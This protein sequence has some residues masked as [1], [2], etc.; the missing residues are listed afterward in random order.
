MDIPIVQILRT[1]LNAYFWLTQVSP[2]E[3][4]SLYQKLEFLYS[5]QYSLTELINGNKLII[6]WNLSSVANS[7]PICAQWVKRNWRKN[8]LLFF[9]VMLIFHEYGI[10]LAIDIKQQKQKLQNSLHNLLY[11]DFKIMWSNVQS[12]WAEKTV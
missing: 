9:Y 12:I 4:A 11:K 2:L 8:F 10:F 1:H 5:F 7:I 6:P 3:N